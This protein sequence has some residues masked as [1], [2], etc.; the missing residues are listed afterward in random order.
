MNVNNPTNP[1][2][3]VRQQDI[4]IETLAGRL[5]TPE[6]ARPLPPAIVIGG[7]EG[8]FGWSNAMGT[9]LAIHGIQSMAVSYFDWNGQFGLPEQMVEIPIDPFEQV[10]EMLKSEQRSECDE[11]SIVGYSRGAE[12]A[13]LLA[14]RF[15]QITR[16]VAYAPSALIWR[17]F[18]I[19]KPMPKSSWCYQGQPI[20]FAHFAGGYFDQIG[21]QDKEQIDQ[22]TIPVEKIAGPLLLI[23]GAEDDVWPAAKMADMSME[24]LKDH[25]HPYRIRHLALNGIG[26]DL[27]VPNFDNRSA[28]K[29]ETD[30]PVRLAWLATI[31]FL[32]DSTNKGVT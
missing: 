24:R 25:N 18:P 30:D 23:S 26:H 5:F 9:A 1:E 4:Q 12:L 20:P 27:G 3:N 10:I 7:S 16:A 28:L 15:P 32:N 31:K 13:L 8:A 2:F 21:W 22:A 14:T 17:G 29:L 6:S 11:L 19:S